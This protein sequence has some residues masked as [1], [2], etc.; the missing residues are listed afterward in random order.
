MEASTKLIETTAKANVPR[1]T[2][3]LAD[4]IQSK[5]TSVGLGFD[6]SVGSD[7]LYAPFIEQGSRPHEIAPVAALALLTD[8]GIYASVQHP[9]TSP[10][11]YLAP[12]LNNNRLQILE[13]FRAAAQAGLALVRGV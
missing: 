2:G 13:L 10:Q 4:S 12:A 1:R 6:G 11:P 3:S 8:V 7:A 9:G 5:V